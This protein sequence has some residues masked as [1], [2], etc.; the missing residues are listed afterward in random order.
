VYPPVLVRVLWLLLVNAI[1]KLARIIAT[2]LDT[3]PDKFD[4]AQPVELH[5]IVFASVD[6]GPILGHSA[7]FEPVPYP[8]PPLNG[9]GR[10]EINCRAAVP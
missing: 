3:I 5:E 1:I 9:T 8:A 2:L 10:I 4:S 7:R 6:F